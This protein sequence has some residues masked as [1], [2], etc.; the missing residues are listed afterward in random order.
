M[1]ESKRKEKNK[2][3]YNSE[4]IEK[5]K[6]RKYAILSK[7][8]SYFAEFCEDFLSF[9]SFLFLFFIVVLFSLSPLGLFIVI[10]RG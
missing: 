8:D 10:F 5:S 2:E 7:K 6:G 1:C 3:M 4:K 9:L